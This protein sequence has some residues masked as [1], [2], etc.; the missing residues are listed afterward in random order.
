MKNLS[1]RVLAL[2]L[3]VSSL[4]LCAATVS[5]CKKNDN[6]G[7]AY[8]PDKAIQMKIVYENKGY[9]YDWLNA[10]NVA[11]VAKHPDVSI[12]VEERP[13]LALENDFEIAK[14][15][16]EEPDIY[17]GNV[18]TGY[19]VYQ[20][21]GAISGKDSAFVELTDVVT[22]AN[23][24]DGTKIED[25]LNA[26][27]ASEYA[28]YHKDLRSTQYY[29]LPY[30]GG[31]A[32]FLYNS[33][34]ISDAA[35][36]NTTDKLINYIKSGQKTVC[37]SNEGAEYMEYVMNTWI[38]QYEGKDRFDAIYNM[39]E[40]N[41]DYSSNAYVKE[42]IL[43][44]Y[45]VGQEILQYPQAYGTDKQFMMLNSE[46]ATGCAALMP[47]G[48]WFASELAKTEDANV[49]IQTSPIRYMKT[50]IISSIVKTL[51][52]TSM[53]DD[54]LS[55][56]VAAIDAGQTSYAGVSANDFETIKAARNIEYSAGLNNHVAIVSTSDNI[57][58]AKDWMWFMASEEGANI[59][60]QNTYT[61]SPYGALNA[62]SGIPFLDSFT[63]AEARSVFVAENANSNAF[64]C[65]YSIS[66]YPSGTSAAMRLLTKD[67]GSF[68]YSAQNVYDECVAAVKNILST[69]GIN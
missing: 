33:N 60:R 59:F 13:E 34:I 15:S 69:A 43:E 10:L 58:T 14:G 17:V 45:K 55:A 61:N 53:T 26:R 19:Y 30:A 54:T 27:G 47:C 11:Y 49:D 32:G 23:P 50:P 5:G 39:R 25:K 62:S 48:N 24:Y 66:R 64:V 63:A 65:Q 21:A 22:G 12:Q 1:K 8:D 4:G 28:Q 42:G 44:A 67:G 38:A 18:P 31:A 3:C 51:E 40:K 7:D 9:G 36:V 41:G 57:D 68:K 6:Y 29:H 20:G 2:A 37:W 16:P 52:D 46:F 35:S 56:V